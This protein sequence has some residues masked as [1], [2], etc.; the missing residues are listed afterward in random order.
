MS[1]CEVHTHDLIR[2]ARTR[3]KETGGG[4]GG[5]RF[6]TPS[7]TGSTDLSHWEFFCNSQIKRPSWCR[8]AAG[9]IRL[10]CQW[11]I[12]PP[13]RFFAH[14]IFIPTTRRPRSADDVMELKELKDRDD[15]AGR[16][17]GRRG[18][19]SERRLL[20]SDST[21]QQQKSEWESLKNLTVTGVCREAG[22]NSWHE[23]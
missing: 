15:P 23:F 21:K 19:A 7:C 13:H 10:A 11:L 3:A 14:L 1:L 2:K 18:A 6:F 8:A 5:N 12:S 17:C 22:T 9:R 4:G 16:L 20:L